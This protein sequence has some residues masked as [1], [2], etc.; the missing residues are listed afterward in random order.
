MADKPS[1]EALE[2]H[3]AQL[4]A[5]LDATRASL[6]T[7]MGELRAKTLDAEAKARKPVRKLDPNAASQWDR[8]FR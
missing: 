5:A 3:V 6:R 7:A 1:Y 4:T 2:A 8:P